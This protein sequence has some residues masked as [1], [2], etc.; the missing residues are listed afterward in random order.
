MKKRR[1]PLRQTPACVEF[2]DLGLLEAVEEAIFLLTLFVFQ[3]MLFVSSLECQ[4]I[5]SGRDAAINSRPNVKAVLGKYGVK[6]N[7]ILVK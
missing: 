6:T 2:M 7:F 4:K 5:E 3:A 1:T